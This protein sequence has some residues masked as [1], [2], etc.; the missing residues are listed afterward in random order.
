[1]SELTMPCIWCGKRYPLGTR[2]YSIPRG[3]RV[4][5]PVCESCYTAFGV[6]MTARQHGFRGTRHC[7]ASLSTQVVMQPVY[8]PPR[9]IKRVQ[10]HKPKPQV[11]QS[12][13]TEHTELPVK[14]T[15]KRKPWV[16]IPRPRGISDLLLPQDP[17]PA[18]RES[19]TPAP[20]S[21]LDGCMA[22]VRGEDWFEDQVAG[23][24]SARLQ[25]PDA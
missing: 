22:A 21:A 19:W 20:V 25:A 6:S 14:V 12:P 13:K 8:G 5:E 16:P 10:P 15:K 11:W 17:L 9:Q 3:T 24:L 2:G 18:R 23:M 7:R 1:M 4:Y